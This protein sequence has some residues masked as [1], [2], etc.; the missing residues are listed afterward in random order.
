MNIFLD[1]LDD[2]IFLCSID[3]RKILIVWYLIQ[4]VG[5][6][7]WKWFKTKISLLICLS[8]D[9]LSQFDMFIVGI[10]LF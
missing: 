4:E 2:Y 9:L 6:R 10:L 1:F 7:L 8:F 5:V 3:K